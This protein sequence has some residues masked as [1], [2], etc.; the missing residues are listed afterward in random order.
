M[1]H[2]AYSI[3]VAQL[4]QQTQQLVAGGSMTEGQL[5]LVFF[6]IDNLNGDLLQGKLL[7]PHNG[8]TLC[9]RRLGTLEP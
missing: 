2:F 1:L 3:H 4:L 7:L 8:F 6:R 9:Q 5:Q